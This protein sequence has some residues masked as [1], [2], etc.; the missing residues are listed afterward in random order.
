MAKSAELGRA[1]QIVLYHDDV[2]SASGLWQ[3]EFAGPRFQNSRQIPSKPHE[4]CNINIQ[5]HS[6]I[7]INIT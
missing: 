3:C 5:I 4:T 1:H 7:N 6:H 2:N